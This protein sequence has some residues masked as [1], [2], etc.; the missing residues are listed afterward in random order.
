MNKKTMSIFLLFIMLFSVILIYIYFNLSTTEE[1]Q[2]NGSN[3]TISDEDI[4]NE[5][6]Q[7]FLDED[8]EIEIGEMV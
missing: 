4:L 5:I 3:E 8:S 2:Y 6:D 1:K 7:I